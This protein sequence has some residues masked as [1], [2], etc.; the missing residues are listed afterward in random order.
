MIQARDCLCFAAKASQGLVRFSLVTQEAL[1]RHDSAGMALPGTIDDPHA[2]TPD[3]FKYLVIAQ[4]P[5]PVRQIHF[6]EDILESLKRTLAL[7][8]QPLE[9]KTAK[10]DSLVRS[11]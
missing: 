6:R 1:Y 5:S 10:A 7:G 8:L 2:A 3:L 4:P 9:Q 11:G